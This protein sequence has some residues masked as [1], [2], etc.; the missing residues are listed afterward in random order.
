MIAV[1]IV[2]I[3]IAF[4]MTPFDYA[5][6]KSF[7]TGWHKRWRIASVVSRYAGCGIILSVVVVWAWRVLP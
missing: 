5:I 3:V 6:W 4:A 7:G 2:L 1:A